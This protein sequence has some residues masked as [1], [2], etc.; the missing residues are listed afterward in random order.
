M[1]ERLQGPGRTGRPGSSGSAPSDKSY[2]IKVSVV[3]AAVNSLARSDADSSSRVAGLCYRPDA[4]QPVFAVPSSGGR[5]D[6]S[7]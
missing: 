3:V 4:A 6:A 1:L 7:W 5:R 2:V